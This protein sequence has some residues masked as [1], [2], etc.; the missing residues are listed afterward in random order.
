MYINWLA[1]LWARFGVRGSKRGQ[2]VARGTK[3]RRAPRHRRQTISCE[4]LEVRALLAATVAVSDAILSEGNSGTTNMVFT[5]TRGGDDALSTLEVA[6][7]TSNGA[8][9]AGTDFTAQTGTVTLA[10]GTTTAT[11]SIPVTGDMLAESH[12]HFNVNLTGVNVIGPGATLGTR[13]D[14][15]N[16]ESPYSVAIGDLNGDGRPDLAMA[17]QNA[18]TISVRFNT[19]SPGATTP[20]FSGRTDF[21]AGVTPRN[22][23]ICDFNGDGRPDI[24]AAN[25]NASTI[26]VFLNTTTPGATSPSLAAKV[27]FAS[28]PG[29]H[30]LL[31]V[32]MN[33]DG[34]ADLVTSN[35]NDHTV[36]VA[37]NTTTPGATVPTFGSPSLFATDLQPRSVAVGDINGD[38]RPDLV[39]ANY[40]STTVSVLL[41]TTTAGASAMSFAT[42]TD[43]TC[44]TTPFYVAIGDL[45]NDGKPDLAV[46]SISTATMTVMFNS[47]AAGATTPAFAPKTDI[48]TG[49]NPLSISIDDLNK[50]GKLDL[51]VMDQLS[52]TVSVFVNTTTPG[53]SQLVL[54]PKTDS[55]IG[56]GAH[57]LATGDLNGDGKVD[58]VTANSTSNDVSVLLNNTVLPTTTLGFGPRADRTVG[59]QPTSVVVVD[60]NLD[61]KPDLVS[62]NRGT[63]SA[64]LNTSSPGAIAPAFGIE[65]VFAAGPSS[66]FVAAGDLN[67]DGKP[68]LVIGNSTANTVEVLFNTTIPGSTTPAFAARQVFATGSNPRGIAIGD[69]NRDGVLDL[70]VANGSTVSVLMNKTVQG[71]GAANFAARTEFATGDNSL[72]VAIGDLNGDGLLDLAVPSID[73][74]TVAVLLNSTTPG[75]LTAAFRNKT[76][77]PT[78]NSPTSAVIGDINGDG[79]PDLAIATA[80]GVSVLR[81]IGAIN[82]TVPSF[83]G[84]TDFATGTLSL[85]V[86]MGDLN[87]DGKP[88]LAVTNFINNTVSVLRNS[89]GVGSPT[90]SF[91]AKQDFALGSAPYSVALGDLSGDGRPDLAVTNR[92]SNTLS[93]LL[94][95]FVADGTGVGFITNDDHVPVFTSSATASFAEKGTGTVLTVNA[96][97]DDLPAQTI[98]Y[99]LS[100]GADQSLFT[101]TGGGI[102]NFRAAPDFE[103][104][105]DAGNNQVYDLQVTA[106]DGAGNTTVQDIAI[107]VTPVNDNPPFFVPSPNE[108][109]V[110]ENMTS[111]GTL[112]VA[113]NDFPAQLLTLSFTYDYEDDKPVY[114]DNSRFDITSDGIVT[115]KE[116]PDYEQRDDLVIFVQVSDGFFSA[117]REFH[118]YVTPVNEYA[119]VFTN[120]ATQ[121]I[122]E[123]TTIITRVEAT[124]SDISDQSITYFLSGGVDQALF[125]ITNDGALSFIT[126]PVFD[127]PSDVGNDNIYNVQVTADDGEGRSA[128]QDMEVIVT[129]P[130][131]VSI[132]ASS[133]EEGDDGTRNMVFTVTRKGNPNSRIE[134]G[135]STTNGTATGGTDFVPQT[136]TVIMQ[137]GY[138]TASVIVPVLGDTLSEADERFSVKLFPISAT[139]TLS[140]QVEFATGTNPRE[141]AL[142]DLNGDGKDDLAIAAIGS[143]Q[144]SILFNTTAPGASVPTFSADTRFATGLRPASVTMGDVNGDGKRDLVVS[145]N[146]ANTVSVFLNTT[147]PGATS[148]TFSARADFATGQLPTTVRMND[149]NGDGRL[150]LVVA[151]AGFTT[152]AVLMNTTAPG[153]TAASFGPRS[154]FVTGTTGAFSLALGDLNND[155][156]ADLAV[157]NINS[158]KVAVLFNTTPTGGNS[159]TFSA[160]TEFATGFGT[161]SVAIEDLDGD[162]IR[163]IAVTNKDSHTVSL[164]RNLTEPGSVNP[165]FASKVEL[166]TGLNPWGI[167]V[168]DMNGDGK[169]DL[170][171]ANAG[172]ATVSIFRNTTEPD[173]PSLSFAQKSD[174]ATGN[175]SAYSVGLGDLNGDG[176]VDV[177]STNFNT[178]A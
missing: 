160:R 85:S 36:G 96:T 176:K 53:S 13:T 38:G 144:V 99:S 158:N 177:I 175:S 40:Q 169:R 172:S 164:F 89:T 23:A 39:T 128:T 31:T 21:A 35:L 106:D 162:G 12:E 102:L 78:G 166:A 103:R 130:A 64:L 93:V 33:G 139:P 90:I 61:G 56:I 5:V 127:S 32:D 149:L 48:A 74:N 41:N 44:G 173:S 110:A 154:E 122:N 120:S 126:T 116:A 148:P 17:N 83:A 67:R 28:G 168:R 137:P 18:N 132:S 66:L 91:S 82:G 129:R 16:A 81:N 141:V 171:V 84:K 73:A 4:V 100:G 125:S 111:V 121:I 68:D 43:F 15:P 165:G 79:Q 142:G 59:T 178:N 54:A 47:T 153:A 42:K 8:A 101:L 95:N 49:I 6:Y 104:P 10:P 94:N 25:I 143:N 146:D 115:F 75:N 37:L 63:V 11:I 58:V 135:Y 112:L 131:T 19:T 60:L 71:S 107:T 174:F 55:A 133:I 65:P 45:N 51:V 97:D 92:D 80:T 20:T 9:T 109:H 136:G 124:D 145:N 22:I 29:P 138:S 156:K 108:F 72:S 147:A 14:L 118:I 27:D 170:V 24:A 30:S 7:T 114:N 163:D 159:P 50:D 86:A 77:F 150:D 151:D 157:A 52:R 152:C 88:D 117:A 2:R 46:A 134:M 1:G 161:N 105:A 70:A 119:P 62:A 57:S 140:S 123:D 167:S 76:D 113:D 87:G 26:S 3:L 69:L 34:K 98:T 155:G